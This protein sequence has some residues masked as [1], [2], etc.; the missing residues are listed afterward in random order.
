LIFGPPSPL[1]T[2]D[3]GHSQTNRARSH[4]WPSSGEI[5]VAF[6]VLAL[7]P[8]GL[9]WPPLCIFKTC[10]GGLSERRITPV[11][12]I[13]FTGFMST[14]GSFKS[15]AIHSSEPG[16][17]T[18]FVQSRGSFDP[19]ANRNEEPTYPYVQ[20]FHMINHA[21]PTS[22]KLQEFNSRSHSRTF[23][24][25]L[26][27]IGGPTRLVRTFGPSPTSRLIDVHP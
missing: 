21:L 22:M 13:I 10:H 6:I 2:L 11:T 8:F 18:P 3:H 25:Q 5:C 23:Q 26:R 20:K 17:K 27:A 12:N 4:L 9:S 19:S 7:S 1:S 16:L 15:T 14:R 24:Q